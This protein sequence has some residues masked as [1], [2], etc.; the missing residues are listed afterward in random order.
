MVQ[1]LGKHVT[2]KFKKTTVFIVV[3]ATLDRHGHFVTGHDI[4]GIKPKATYKISSE[5]IT[6]SYPMSNFIK[7]KVLK[8]YAHNV[9]FNNG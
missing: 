3:K 6:S 9:N 7:S 8:R 2:R 1:S 4:L 5:K